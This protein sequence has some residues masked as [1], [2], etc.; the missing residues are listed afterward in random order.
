MLYSSLNGEILKWSRH[1]MQLGAVVE[2]DES[3]VDLSQTNSSI[4]FK[5]V[6]AGTISMSPSW[7]L[8]TPE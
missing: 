2:A 7:Y 8:C 4:L 6:P 5:N 3:I 1:Q